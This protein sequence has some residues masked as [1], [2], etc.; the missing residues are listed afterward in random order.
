VAG[1]RRDVFESVGLHESPF[2]P[3]FAPPS[4]MFVRG[5]GTELFDIEGRRYL[6]FLSGIAVTSLRPS[7]LASRQAR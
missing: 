3:V 7:C 4:V 2:M 6:D 1:E 5:K